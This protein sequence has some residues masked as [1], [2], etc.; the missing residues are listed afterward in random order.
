MRSIEAGKQ[1]D[2][3]KMTE[4]LN[5]RVFY[6]AGHVAKTALLSIESESEEYVKN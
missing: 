4:N 2:A 5:G 3:G 6:R 1:I